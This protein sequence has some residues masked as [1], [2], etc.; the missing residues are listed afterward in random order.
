MYRWMRAMWPISPA[1]VL[2][3]H[4]RLTTR[5][6]AEVQ[7]MY[8]R[9]ITVP[10]RILPRTTGPTRHDPEPMTGTDLDAA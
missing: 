4:L 3:E 1:E 2:I 6:T 7:D 5:K 10:V 9:P 8:S